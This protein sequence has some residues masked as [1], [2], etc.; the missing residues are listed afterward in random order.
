MKRFNMMLFAIL[1]IGVS[2]CL[3]ASWARGADEGWLTPGQTFQ[4]KAEKGKVLSVKA[5]TK[6]GI[7]CVLVNSGKKDFDWDLTNNMKMSI[8]PFAYATPE[9][10]NFTV[11]VDHC[12]HPQGKLW[13]SYKK[14]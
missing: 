6:K 2:V 10:P 8:E 12:D 7:V 4:A 11:K 13:Y 14:P 1:M 5:N 9:K 3:D